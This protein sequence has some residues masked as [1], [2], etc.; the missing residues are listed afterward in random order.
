M[1]SKYAHLS[2]EE[3]IAQL[4]KRDAERKLGLVWER[5]AI[6]HDRALN[7]DFVALNLVPDLSVGGAPYQNLVIEGDNFDALR[8]LSIAY[9]S[10]VKCIYIDPPYNT[11]NKDFIYNDRFVEKDDAWK[12]SKWLEFMY[13]RLVLARDLLKEDG[14]IL[15]SINDENR[16]KLEL[17]LDQVFPGRRLGS[18]VWRT[19]DTGNDAGGNF[20]QVHEH[21]LAYANPQFTFNGKSLN[22]EKYRYEDKDGYKYTLNP[23]TK[24]HTYKERENTYYPIQDPKTGYWYP[25]DPNA[26]WRFATKAKLKPGQKIRTETIEELIEKDLIFFPACKPSE[27]MQWESMEE[28]LESIRKG[29]GPV[30]PKKKTPLLREELPDLAFWVGKPIAPGRPSKKGYLHV[31]DS[32]IAPISSWIAGLNEELNLTEEEMEGEIE[33]LRSARGGEGTDTINEIL[34]TKA[35]SFPKPPSLIRGLISQATKEDDIVLDFFAGS[36]TTGH[37][38]LG[39]NAEDRKNRKFILISNTEATLEAP[40]KNLCRDVCAKRISRVIEGY[41]GKPGTGGDFAYMVAQRIPFD[42]L[43]LDIQHGQVW[44]TLQLA[45]NQGVTPFIENAPFQQA[46]GASTVIYIPELNPDSRAAVV[47]AAN[48]TKIPMVIYTW[49]PGA[50]A[51]SIFNEHVCVEQVP[52]YLTERFLGGIA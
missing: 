30:L 37:A 42:N 51:Q 19:K 8:Y 24:A 50:L 10:R 49:Q 33:Y 28:L 26:V 40:G 31:K 25:C 36:G 27:V 14:I 44:Y 1:Q 48:E 15:V 9:R 38:V 32:L 39:L 16:A 47:S 5:N 4:M 17:L 52:E 22:L 18:F 7:G 34:G 3:L 45:H 35:F 11:G 41:N 13:R 6:E 29:K 2:K 43:L 46:H 21:V 12:H 20:S 23:I